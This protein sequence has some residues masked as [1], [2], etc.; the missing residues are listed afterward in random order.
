MDIVMSE[1]CFHE[2]QTQKE[3]NFT[4]KMVGGS[5]VKEAGSW[6]CVLRKSCKMSQEV[7]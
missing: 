3:L 5:S 2:N 6:Q 4:D 1:V 7:F